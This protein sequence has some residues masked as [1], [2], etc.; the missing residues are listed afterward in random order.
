MKQAEGAA[1]WK[2]TAVELL[3]VGKEHNCHP[4]IQQVREQGRK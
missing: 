1:I 4:H 2:T 3:I